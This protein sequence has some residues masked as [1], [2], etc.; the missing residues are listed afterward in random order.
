MPLR[1][2]GDISFRAYLIDIPAGLPYKLRY[3]PAIDQLTTKVVS[4]L[5]IYYLGYVTMKPYVLVC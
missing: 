3:P 2:I 4:S 5:I 1:I